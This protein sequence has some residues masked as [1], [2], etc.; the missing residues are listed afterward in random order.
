MGVSGSKSAGKTSQ[1]MVIVRGEVWWQL[2]RDSW[3]FLPGNWFPL[4]HLFRLLCRQSLVSMD[5]LF[6]C[7]LCISGR[8]PA[9]RRRPET[10]S[11]TL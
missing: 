11:N 1:D 9:S 8:P 4:Q 10:F 5:L 7:L 6:S 3:R 2:K